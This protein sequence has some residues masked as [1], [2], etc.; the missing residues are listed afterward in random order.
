MCKHRLGPFL[1]SVTRPN[2]QIIAVSARLSPH[3]PSPDRRTWGFQNPHQLLPHGRPVCWP[4]EPPGERRWWDALLH[5]CSGCTPASASQWH[6]ETEVIST[7]QHLETEV[8]NKLQQ[9]KNMSIATGTSHQ[10]KDLST[11][12]FVEFSNYFQLF[13]QHHI[14]QFSELLYLSWLL[15]PWGRRR[16]TVQGRCDDIH[17]C[18]RSPD[19]SSR[20]CSWRGGTPGWRCGLSHCPPQYSLGIKST[21]VSNLKY[22]L[23][24]HTQKT[25]IYFTLGLGECQHWSYR[26]YVSIKYDVIAYYWPKKYFIIIIII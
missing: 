19:G 13:P 9:T 3:S 24:N 20:T 1:Q 2:S 16:G 14:S 21:N 5:L 26:D 7:L 23:F 6:L 8:I 11:W 18:Q 12:N 10:V 15:C 25:C 22:E 17:S 4:C